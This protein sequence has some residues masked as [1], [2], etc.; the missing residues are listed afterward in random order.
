MVI[1]TIHLN[2]RCLEVRTDSPERAAQ[3]F[4]R[5]AIEYL[6]S[7]FRHKDQVDMQLKNTVSAVS[8]VVVI[9]HRPTI[10]EA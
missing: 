6:A 7:I 4:N 10:I 5:I 1:F 3:P 8:N 9:F 2:K